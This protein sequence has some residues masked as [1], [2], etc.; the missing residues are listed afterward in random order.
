MTQRISLALLLL[1]G[2]DNHGHRVGFSWISGDGEFAF[3]WTGLRA[4]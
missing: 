3:R 2:A 4:R 1:L